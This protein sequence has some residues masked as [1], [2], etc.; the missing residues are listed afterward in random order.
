MMISDMKTTEKPLIKTLLK[1]TK[2]NFQPTTDGEG[3]KKKDNCWFVEA[4]TH[5]FEQRDRRKI[6]EYGTTW[7]SILCM[8][9]IFFNLH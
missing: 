4:V 6:E 8:I 1:V 9:K 5:L 3:V 2:Y 7:I